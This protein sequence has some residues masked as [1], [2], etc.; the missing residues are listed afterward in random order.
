MIK[1]S[2]YLENGKIR[3]YIEHL[4]NNTLSEDDII[5][6]IMVLRDCQGGSEC[7]F[8]K[9]FEVCEEIKGVEN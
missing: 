6:A 4:G 2:A 3:R 8:C 1:L 5:E 7:R 9:D